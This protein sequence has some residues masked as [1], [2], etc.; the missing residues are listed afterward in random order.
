MKSNKKFASLGSAVLALAF[1]L[2]S[3]VPV[4]YA[5]ANSEFGQIRDSQAYQ[6]FRQRPVNDFSKLMY[7]I[8][9]F[10]GEKIQIVY[11][12]HYFDA[13]FSAKIAKWFLGRNYKKETPREWIMRWCNT[14]ISGQLIWVKMPSGKFKLS[15][16]VLM[17]E[18][19]DLDQTILED[20]Q[21][22]LSKKKELTSPQAAALS[23]PKVEQAAPKRPTDSPLDAQPDL[24]K[25]A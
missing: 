23:F 19:K 5:D 15:R 18:I 7:M 9:R 25:K 3:V 17:E 12:N 6:H 24:L 8:D 21:L 14:S 20:E 1:V 16:E 22:E 4:A 11:D 2:S 10:S 13:Q